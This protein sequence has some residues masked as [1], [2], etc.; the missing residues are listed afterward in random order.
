MGWLQ[1]L[2]AAPPTPLRCCPCVRPLPLPRP[3]HLQY[4]YLLF[5][6]GVLLPLTL[7]IDGTD[8]GPQFA[9]WRAGDWLVL[10]ATGCLVCV[11]ANVAIQ[12]ST[13]QL[14]APTVSMFYGLRLV[15]SIL[16]SKFILSTTV[17][18]SGVQ[19]AGTVVT[20]AAVSVYMA[21]QWRLSK[22]QAVAAS[23]AKAA[24]AAA[25]GAA[26]LPAQAAPR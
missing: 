12:H 5:S 16:F 9:A 23:S 13:W 17:V 7:P 1:A 2:A 14:G 8:W 3:P 26:P 10:A 19:I 25:T 18:T 6:V 11:G 4:C 20:V 15:A 21:H 22:Q 24:A